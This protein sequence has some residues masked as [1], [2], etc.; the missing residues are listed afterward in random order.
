MNEQ[1]VFFGSD[2]NNTQV[3]GRHTVIPIL[4]GHAFPF[5]DTARERAVS[6]RAAMTK[7]FMGTMS[8]GKST[9]AVPLDDTRISAPFRASNN[10][11][12]L[13][14]LKNLRDVQ[15][16]P[17][18]VVLQVSNTE[19]SQHEKWSLPGRLAMPKQRFIRALRFAST[20]AKLECSV[21]ILL[22]SLFLYHRAGT[23]LYDGYRHEGAIRTKHLA[24]SQFFPDESD[25]MG[26]LTPA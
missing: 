17:N 3:R 1:E 20:E 21:S 9:H 22:V 12:E 25:H 26:F 16:A 4:S 24:H 19:F 18:L 13:T 15:F 2:F 5:E 23:S 10:V 14:R 7:V 6:Y 8:S 11:N